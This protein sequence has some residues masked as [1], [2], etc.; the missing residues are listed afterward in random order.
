[1]RCFLGL[2]CALS[3]VLM[4]AQAADARQREVTRTVVFDTEIVAPA[5]QMDEYRVESRSPESRPTVYQVQ[6]GRQLASGTITRSVTRTHRRHRVVL[7]PK[8]SVASRPA[9]NSGNTSGQQSACLCGPRCRC[10]PES[11]IN[12]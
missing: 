2:V 10:G 5:M 11:V 6:E 1:M 9:G 12:R 4:F 7:I 8:S 3:V